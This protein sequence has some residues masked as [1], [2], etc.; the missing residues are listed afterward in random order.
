[1]QQFMIERNFGKVTE[2]DLA[3]LGSE[4]KRVAAAEF[5]GRIVWEHSHAAETP[6][7]L[8]TYCVYQAPDADTIRKHA[9]AAGLPCDRVTPI[10]TVGPNDFA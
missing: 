3:K 7:G 9:A 10:N 5:A 4:S 2:Q 8:M 1:M 6:E